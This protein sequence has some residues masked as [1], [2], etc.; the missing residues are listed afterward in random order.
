MTT[1]GNK[2]RELIEQVMQKQLGE[3]GFS[4]AIKNKSADD[5]FGTILGAGTYQLTIY[6][7]SG[8][9]VNPGLCSILCTKNI[10]TKANDQ[11][12]NNL[13]R[14]SVPAADPL[15][16]Q[17]DTDSNQSTRIA[18][19]KQADQL[20]AADQVSLPLDPLPNIGL[21]S[22]PAQRPDRG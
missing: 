9:S 21:W 22:T 3:N 12:G 13:S 18:A 10:P 8:T 11:T 14:V 2:Q 7:S 15:L 6:G 17:V 4:L 20:L 1:A 16:E 5:L 19:S